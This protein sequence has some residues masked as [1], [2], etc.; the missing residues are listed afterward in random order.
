MVTSPH[1]SRMLSSPT[2]CTDWSPRHSTG[3]HWRR[4]PHSSGTQCCWSLILIGWGRAGTELVLLSQSLAMSMWLR[5]LQQ[6]ASLSLVVVE[7]C[8]G[9]PSMWAG[10]EGRQWT[11]AGYVGISKY[12][13][14]ISHNLQGFNCSTGSNTGKPCGKSTCNVFWASI[15]LYCDQEGHASVGVWCWYQYP[16][17]SAWSYW[18]AHLDMLLSVLMEYT[19]TASVVVPTV[20]SMSCVCA[21]TNSFSTLDYSIE[22]KTTS[23]TVMFRFPLISI[24]ALN[25]YTSVRWQ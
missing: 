11:R 21:E 23:S 5:Y 15:C 12:W 1:T 9:Q 24:S 7:F 6:K 20:F 4:T 3:H 10:V 14:T 13:R 22:N 2:H 16:H 8:S 18:K 19:V 17:S 25:W